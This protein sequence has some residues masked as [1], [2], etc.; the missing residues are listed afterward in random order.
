[1]KTPAALRRSLAALGLF[2]LAA[3]AHAA[4]QLSISRHGYLITQVQSVPGNRRAFDVTA[5]AAVVNAGDRATDVAAR[6]TSTH[7]NVV[8]LDGVVSFGDVPRN[9][10]LNPRISRDTFK[11]RITVPRLMSLGQLLTFVHGAHQS[12]SWQVSYGNGTPQNRAPTADAGA[13]QT[14]FLGQPATLNGGGS[15]DPDGQALSYSWSLVSRPTGSSA[16]LVNATSVQPSITPDREGDYLIQLV[17]ADG[18][19]TSAPDTVQVSTLNA[20]PVANAGADQTAVTGTAVVLNGSG[21]TDVDGDALT[22]SWSIVS[23]PAGSLAEIVDPSMVLAGFTPDLPG[24]YLLELVV[25]DGFVSST[26]DSV[27]ISTAQANRPPVFTLGP[28]RTQIVDGGAVTLD[29]SDAYDPEGDLMTAAWSLL[30]RP[31]GS[32]AQLQGQGGLLNSLHPIDRGGLYVVQLT[33]TDSQGASATDTLTISTVNS[34]PVAILTAPGGT[35]APGNIVRLDGGSSLDSDFDPLTYRWSLLSI[36]AASAA[37]LSDPGIVTPEFVTD[38]PGTYVVQL[39][40]NDGHVDSAPA[41]GIWEAVPPTVV[42]NDVDGVADNV[43]NGAPN[44]GDG[45]GDGVPDATQPNVTSLPN[46]VDGRYVTLVTPPGTLMSNVHTPAN[47]SPADAPAGVLFPWGFFEFEIRGLTSPATTLTILLPDGAAPRSYWK[48]GPEPGSLPPHWYEFMYDDDSETGAAL[49]ANRVVLHLVDGARG[50][51]TLDTF[52]VIFDQGGPTV[53]AGLVA[54]AGPDQ[55]VFAR[56]KTQL[57]GSRSEEEG[58]VPMRHDWFV[59]DAPPDSRFRNSPGAVSDQARFE[60]RPDAY[61]SYLLRLVVTGAGGQ[62][63]SDDISLI[64]Q[65][66]GRIRWLGD[67]LENVPALRPVPLAVGADLQTWVTFGITSLV[68]GEPSTDDPEIGAPEVNWSVAGPFSL[69]P[70]PSY[71][72]SGPITTG[73]GAGAARTLLQSRGSRG[74]VGTLTAVSPGFIGAA[75]PL[76][77][78]AVA[79]VVSPGQVF[80]NP[81]APPL[82][83]QWGKKRV[84][85][86][87]GVAVT[88]ESMLHEPFHCPQANC[89]WTVP[90]LNVGN[91]VV[92]RV[93]GSTDLPWGAEWTPFNALRFEPRDPGVTTITIATLT[94][95]VAPA[96]SNGYDSRIEVSN[97]APQVDT[98]SVQLTGTHT[99]ANPGDTATFIVFAESAVAFED[100][101]VYL[102]LPRGMTP[103]TATADVG[104]VDWSRRTWD[105]GA[106][107]GGQV[108]LTFTVRVTE[109]FFGGV[110]VAEIAGYSGVPDSTPVNNLAIGNIAGPTRTILTNDDFIVIKPDALRDIDVLANDSHPQGS[111]GSLPAS[112]VLAIQTPPAHGTAV[113][114]GRLLRYV[115][116]P[117]FR[118]L[119]TIRYRVSNGAHE[120]EIATLTIVVGNRP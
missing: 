12:L 76:R 30:S 70:D 100:L 89:A 17:V 96:P 5:R 52:D 34:A 18:A 48:Y 37:T 61:G 65:P 104:T 66:R 98:M 14:T 7:P 38:L 45:N 92:G 114:A 50:D 54:R 59:I 69:S 47:P 93:V 117:G 20:A 25:D 46:S 85:P 73:G 44:Q 102:K 91:A 84:D 49:N 23:R 116:A 67:A 43:E 81:T 115:P 83:L 29:A 78:D 28:D 24:D 82:P 79:R 103:Q 8:V 4:P 10:V 118:G 108:M 113:I 60:F 36:P 11:L 80:T 19:L 74:D 40:V 57:D 112:T 119:D 2:L 105:L 16:T 31:A 107:P 9:S 13:D 53:S 15:S 68:P 87:T 21:S 75:Q 95:G 99:S 110:I 58:A 42:D 62:T 22:Y 90:S 6:L 26:P 32:Q 1:M 72:G 97:G 77:T 39:V 120:V 56:I 86:V 94:G 109:D 71:Y 41:T 27:L 33:L 55:E 35:T 64:A 51:D 106:H 88:S 63:A 111:P 3:A 101:R